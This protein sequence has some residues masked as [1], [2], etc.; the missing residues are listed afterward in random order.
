MI[1]L[2]KFTDMYSIY[3]FQRGMQFLEIH[4]DLHLHACKFKYI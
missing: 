2:T 4:I 3:N 1:T